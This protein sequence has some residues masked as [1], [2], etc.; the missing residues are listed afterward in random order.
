MS[1]LLFGFS[2][3]KRDEKICDLELGKLVHGLFVGDKIDLVTQILLDLIRQ[4]ARV[5]RLIPGGMSPID[6]AHDSDLKFILSEAGGISSVTDDIQ[7]AFGL[8]GSK[9]KEKILFGR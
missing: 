1:G 7:P 9:I 4:G 8:S 3:I 5:N 6:K 2:H